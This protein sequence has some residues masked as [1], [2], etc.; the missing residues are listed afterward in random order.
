VSTSL[1]ENVVRTTLFEP[2]GRSLAS[3]PDVY[4][5]ILEIRFGIVYLLSLTEV[6]VER[7]GELPE[8][9]GP[10]IPERSH[11]RFN[12]SG[13]DPAVLLVD[14]LNAGGSFPAGA[15]DRCHECR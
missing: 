15:R 11:P 2:R 12:V 8:R 4:S 10:G 5:Q 1:D 9:F 14:E 13:S 3:D 6:A 7:V